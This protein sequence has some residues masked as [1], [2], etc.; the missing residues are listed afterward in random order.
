MT[1]IDPELRH[2]ERSV[3]KSQIPRLLQSS[4]AKLDGVTIAI[5]VVLTAIAAFIPAH[6]GE[7]L[8]KAKG[9]LQTNVPFLALAVCIAA[10][11]KA[12]GTE[13]LIARAAIGR[14]GRMV[15]MFAVFGALTPFCSC[16]VIPIIASLLVAGIPLPPV[17]AFWMSSPLMDPNQFIITAGELGLQFAVAR[18]IAAIGM[19]LLSGYA[20][21]LLI[22]T[23]GLSDPLRFKVRIIG[24]NK[25][26]PALAKTP[27]WKFWEDDARSRLFLVHAAKS[28]WFLI[29]WLTLAFLLEGIMITF[30][31]PSAIASWL[32]SGGAGDIPLAVA[33]GSV[34][35]M[36]AFAAIPLVSGLLKLGMSQGAGLAFLVAGSATSIPASMAVYALVTR[37]VF[38][39]HLGM[40]I[41]GALLTGYAYS[42]FLMAR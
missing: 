14:E 35:Y 26:D 20:T 16:G 25:Y 15:L 11:A 24:E 2:A 12:T 1:A 41:I 27:K 36:N 28:F 7:V 19:G 42:A 37:K 8:G 17:M 10:A 3:F 9:A 6:A 4:F 18:A 31:P 40:A 34:I 23:F 22:R 13:G 21:M 32:G 5:L 29:R 33:L 30:I 38:L 39:W